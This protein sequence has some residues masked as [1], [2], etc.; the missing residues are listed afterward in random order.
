MNGIRTVQIQAYPRIHITLIG[1]NEDGFRIN[2]GIGFSIDKPN[3]TLEIKQSSHF[4]IN[5]NRNS[6]LDYS[7]RERLKNKLISIKTKLNLDSEIIISISGSLPIHS[8][9]GSGTIVRLACIEGLLILNDLKYDEDTL[10]QLSGRGGT[11]GIGV[12]T[13]F[14]GGY[15]FDIGHKNIGQKL[16]PS[17]EMEIN[18]IQSLVISQGLMPIWRFGICYPKQRIEIDENETQFF[19]N[20]AKVNESVVFKTLY[21]VVYSTLAGIIEN[22]ID[23]F[24]KGINEIQ[25]MGWKKSEKDLYSDNVYQIESILYKNGASMVGMS[26]LGPGLYFFAEDISTVIAKSEQDINDWYFF[27]TLTNNVGR[28]LTIKDA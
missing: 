21:N 9:F 20:N 2:G 1:M 5:D 18:T 14:K 3:I 11:S 17:S 6:P 27:S 13:Y 28:S 25:L 8:G 4:Q 23:C 16:L 15:V 22:D 10:I 19:K 26:S 12:R 7:Q 24:Q